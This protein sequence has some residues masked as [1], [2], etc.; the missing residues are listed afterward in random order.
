MQPKRKTPLAG[1]ID[2]PNTTGDS[3]NASTYR[4]SYP[5][6]ANDDQDND[7]ARSSLDM[8]DS[9]YDDVEKPILRMARAAARYPDFATM[10]DTSMYTDPYKDI[11][12]QAALSGSRQSLEF[13]ADAA[14]E[15]SLSSLARLQ[16][17]YQ[18]RCSEGARGEVMI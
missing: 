11:Q 6:N 18:H 10:M 12:S 17:E 14:L 4:Y 1:E 13:D 8:E 15:A 3:E 2:N 5:N 9:L 16:F 7:D